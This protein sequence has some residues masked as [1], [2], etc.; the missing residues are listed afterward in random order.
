MYR[1]IR[2]TILSLAALAAAA[3]GHAEIVKVT[4]VHT[5]DIHGGINP[6]D[7]TFMNRE[8]PPRLGGAASMVTLLR[9]LRSEVEAGSGHFL[10]LDAGDTFQGTPVGTLTKGRAVIDFMNAAG[11]DLLALGNRPSGSFGQGT[12][13]KAAVPG[14][15]FLS[16]VHHLDPGK[17]LYRGDPLR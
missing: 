13:E 11:Y 17:G 14:L 12:A 5:N 15:E 4:V 2:A 7:A 1:R 10:L 3:P 16:L 6:A 9:R 8:F